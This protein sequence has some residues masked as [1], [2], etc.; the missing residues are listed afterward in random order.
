MGKAK[1]VVKPEVVKPV[2]I[3]ISH[4]KD[5]KKHKVNEIY[6]GQSVKELLKKG[7]IKVKS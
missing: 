1:K 5:R 6:T 3:V 4:F 7:L 2:Y